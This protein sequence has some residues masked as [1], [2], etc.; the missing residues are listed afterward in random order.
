MMCVCVID[1]K[2]VLSLLSDPHAHR[3]LSHDTLR[4]VVVVCDG[5][6]SALRREHY[7]RSGSGFQRIG[8]DE[9]DSACHDLRELQRSRS[10]RL[11]N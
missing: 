6:R 7:A 8:R 2:C 9:A 3:E 10:W 5:I 11:G 4:C 1:E